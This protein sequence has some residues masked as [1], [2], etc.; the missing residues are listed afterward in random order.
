VGKADYFVV[1]LGNE[2]SLAIKIRFGENMS[3]KRRVVN[4]LDQPA[5]IRKAVPEIDQKWRISI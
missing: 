3:L 1:L 2:K 4:L 5:D